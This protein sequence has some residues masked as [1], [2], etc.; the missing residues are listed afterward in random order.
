[1]NLAEWL[2]RTAK[3][4]AERPALLL[5]EEVVASYADFALH[6]AQIAASLRL[7]HGIRPGDRVAI[8][9]KNSPAYLELLYGI[10]FCGA[11]AVPINAKLHAREAA[12]IIADSESRVAFVAG[13]GELA[14]LL[15]AGCTVHD[16]ETAPAFEADGDALAAP[17]ARQADDLAWLFYTSGTTGKPKGVMLSNANLH[18]MTYAYFVD[19]DDVL[20]EDAAVY[21]APLSHGAGLYNFMHV[22]RGSRHVIPASGG[23]DAL[24]ICALAPRL[25]NVTMFAAPTMINRLLS[26]ARQTG[27]AGEGLRTIVYGGG[28]MYLADIEAATAQFGARFVQI[29]GQGESPMTLTALPR[30][31]IIDRSHPRWRDR[32][33]SVGRAQSCVRIRIVGP[34]GED[35]ATGEIGEII[36]S[37]SPVMRGYWNN[38]D[39][40]AQAI[41]D[42]WLW[43]GD[44][45][46]L[47]E[48]GYLTLRDRS[49]DVIISGGTNIYP[50]E[51]EEALLTHP[52]VAE[53]S[54][55]G[56]PSAEW[57][58]EV[59]AVVVLAGSETPSASELDAHCRT[60]IASFKRPKAYVFE[61]EL[62]KNNYGKVLKTELRTR[63][64]AI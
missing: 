49:K 62:P 12:F 44:M 27:Y 15:P 9:M 41:R 54:V 50:R 59:V 61:T 34:D 48:D 25:N 42:G 4:H 33:A 8:F 63:F 40:T 36:A 21:A 35:K 58:E 5:G 18:A 17:V 60:Q 28:P 23:F 51:V 38:P 45:G 19:V 2:V 11:V 53:V 3:R 20:E 52:G 37:G 29:Y 24:E 6:A 14:A 32:L 55:I 56:R 13:E 16:L 22:L 57:G 46:S 30:G 64:S 1:M 7:R 47:D 31:D 10:W 39:A 26:V 43:T